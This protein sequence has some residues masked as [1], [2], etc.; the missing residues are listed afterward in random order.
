MNVF[1][2]AEQLE[3]NP[4]LLK[5]IAA[6]N[7]ESAGAARSREAARRALLGNETLQ[8]AAERSP[9][10][11]EALDRLAAGKRTAPS[12]GAGFWDFTEPSTRLALLPPDVLSR[13]G[14]IA[15]AA[16][17]GERIAL[18]VVKTQ[19]EAL[20][21]TL[22]DDVYA[23]ALKRGRWQAGALGGEAKKLLPQDLPLEDAC[24]YL[25]RVL[26]ETQRRTWPEDLQHLSGAAFSALDLPVVE[27]VPAASPDAARRYW[28][29]LKKLILRELDSEWPPYFN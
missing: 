23:Y 3:S 13:L 25:A 4:A 14:K 27:T 15:A 10:I 9:D 7:A 24:L 22:G 16:L 6:F 8:A 11:L 20:K 12:A 17:L 28:H 26:L 1:F 2:F 21:K 18:V 19:V 29:F 5:R